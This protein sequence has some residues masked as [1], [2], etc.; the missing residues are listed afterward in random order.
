MSRHRSHGAG[1][2][3]EP[4]LHAD[5]DEPGGI[6]AERYEGLGAHTLGGGYGTD[7]APWINE[8]FVI[9]GMLIK[10]VFKLVTWPLRWTWKKSRGTTLS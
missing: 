7:F 8:V 4:D 1:D 6:P 9:A 3:A 5:W 2:T 10:V